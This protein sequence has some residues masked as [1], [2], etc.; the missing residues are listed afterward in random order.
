MTDEQKLSMS[1]LLDIFH[2]SGLKAREAYLIGRLLKNQSNTEKMLNRLVK[3]GKQRVAFL[4][5]LSLI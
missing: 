5:P 1:N 4:N 3:L 2:R